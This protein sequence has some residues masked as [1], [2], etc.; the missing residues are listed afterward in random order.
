MDPNRAIAD[1]VESNVSAFVHGVVQSESR[2]VSGSQKGEAKEAFFQMMNEWF[3]DLMFKMRCITSEGHNVSVVEYSSISGAERRVTWE[4]F[5]DEFRKKCISQRFI[6]QK[7]NEFEDGLNKDIR[8]LVG[9]LELKEFVVLLSGKDNLQISRPSNTVARGRPPRSD[10]NVISSKA[11]LMLLPFDEFDVI[12]GRFLVVFIDDVLIYS[13][14]ESEHA[15]HLRIVLQTLRDKQLFAKFSKCEFWLREVRFLGLIVST[16]GIRVDLSKISTVVVWKPPR[17]VSGVRNFLGLAGYYR[18]FS[19]EQLKA[20]LTEAPVLVQPESGKEFV[21]FSDMSLNGLGCVLM[22]EGKVIAYASRQLKPHEKNYS[23]DNL[24]LAANVFALKIWRHHLFSEK[25]H[26]FTGHKS[27]KYL[28]TQNDLNLRQ[29][30]RL[31]LLKD[32]ELVIDYHPGKVNIVVD[33]LS[34]KSLFSL[35][36][37]N[38]Q[39]TISDDGSILAELKAKP[40]FL[41]QICEA[42]KCDNELQAKR[43]QYESTSDSDYQIGCDDCLMFRSR[44]CV[45]KNSELIQKI[46][47]EADSE[48]KWDRVTMDFVLGLPLSP[49]KKDAIWVVV[50]RLI[51]S[52]HF[53]LVC[54]EPS[55]Q[56]S[57]KMALY[58]AL[59]GRKCRTP[60][61]W[62]ELSKKKIHRVDL[63][64]ET[65]EK[66]KVICDSLKTALD[67]QKS[68][69]DLKR[70]DIEF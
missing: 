69:V 18:L 17:N 37:M 62:T 11:N 14:D 35:R 67:R 55:F 51:K 38:T 23:K 48:W 15:E 27:L 64:R 66:V 13:R 2:L 63:I 1:D 7:Q 52:A 31:E 33:A 44:I 3:T 30:R 29:R 47:H 59:Y 42:Q 50:D 60:L 43:V 36:A 45:P 41:Q 58:E 28:I 34:R 70:K 8:L 22:Q 54:R 61:Y 49:K 68:Y 57:I 16:E 46:I 65:E 25:C 19:F 21:I 40:L 24:E 53:I 5:Q 6:V 39:L 56:S 26:I 10:G 20:L 9:I 12:L 4:F 32:Y